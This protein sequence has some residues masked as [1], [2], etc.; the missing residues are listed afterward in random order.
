M[1]TQEPIKL[2]GHHV[3]V[4]A[5]N[6]FFH[7]YLYPIRV[8][9]EII[10]RISSPSRVRLK[11]VW[12]WNRMYLLLWKLRNNPKTSVE[13]VEGLDSICEKCS[14]RKSCSIADGFSA[15]GQH[16]Q[17]FDEDFFCLKEYGLKPGVYPAREIIERTTRYRESSTTS[18]R[19]KFE[20]QLLFGSNWQL[21]KQNQ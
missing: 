3:A 6:N 8:L 16:L 21:R 19:E 17:Q 20:R 18:P 14:V 10:N 9:G 5:D 12:G 7:P 11:E 2:R 4:M 15:Y 1:T 13:I